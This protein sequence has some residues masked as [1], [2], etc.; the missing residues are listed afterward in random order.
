MKTMI[1]TLAAATALTA[2]AAAAQPYG[3]GR[4]DNRWTDIDR[5]Q[6]QLA[7]RID[8]GVR[9]GQLTR[10]EA[11]RLKTEFNRVARLEARYRVN[12]LS[13]WERADLDRRMDILSN[14]VRLSRRDDERRYGYND[15][16][17]Y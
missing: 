1:V 9:S 4:H 8:Q 15:Y 16:P 7:F 11:Y 6:E 12:G 10:R 14:D 5:R 2:G 3:Y 13:G 17:R